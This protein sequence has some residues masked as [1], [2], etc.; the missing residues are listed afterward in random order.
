[1]PWDTGTFDVVYASH[2]LEHTTDIKAAFSEIRRILKPEGILLFAV[3]CGYDEEPAHTYNRE[4][5][6]WQEDFRENG[7][8]VVD[9]GR[10]DFNDNEFYGVAKPDDRVVRQDTRPAGGS[11]I[12]RLK[13]LFRNQPTLADI[14]SQLCTAS[15]F[16]ESIYGYWLSE[17]GQ[18]F[19]YHRKPWEYVFILQ[20]LKKFDLLKSGVR[21]L[22]FGCGK[23]PLAAAMAKHGCEIMATDIEPFDDSDD[24]WGARTAA[25]LYFP[26]V[27]SEELFNERVSF[28]YADMNQ[29]P[30]SLYDDYD[31]VWSCCAL[32]HLGSLAAGMDF[33][34]NS[35]VCLRPGGVAVHTT[36]INLT[37]GEDTMET[38]GLS[39]YR[40]K[41]IKA[42]EKRLQENGCS[43]LPC[44]WYSGDLPEDKHIDLPPYK[45]QTH[46]KLMIERYVVTS[47]GLVIIK[48]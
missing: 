27:C 44:N 29:F 2:I 17:M 34:L 26:G 31:F 6:E 25:D 4:F 19:T 7:W 35:T 1:L 9:S 18:N 37:D 20:A 13:G 12:R 45:Q 30:D 21:G 41:D 36:E 48:D 8:Q 11:I 38:P 14:T 22:G 46:L 16:Q 33:I 39:L 43:M 24:Y 32:E 40:K 3:P 47:L 23:E 5:E 10:F 42:L 28:S 15:Q